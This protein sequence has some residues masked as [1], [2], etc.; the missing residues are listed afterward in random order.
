M[1]LVVPLPGGEIRAQDTGGDGPALVLV[2]PGW[3]DAD[4]WSRLIN[5]LPGHYRV[6]HYD[7]RGFGRSPLSTTPFTRTDDLRAV[8]DYAGI[9]H[10]VIVAHSGGGGTALSLALSDPEPR[11]SCSLPGWNCRRRPPSR[12]WARY[13]H[14]R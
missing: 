4:I 6:L 2:H 12:D 5:L 1:E 13:E 14:Q 9:L 7:D 11:S 10:A 3:G 8:L